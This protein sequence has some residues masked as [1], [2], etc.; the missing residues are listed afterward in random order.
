VSQSWESEIRP[1]QPRRAG[2]AWALVLVPVLAVAVFGF[3]GTVGVVAITEVV[4]D[5]TGVE[6]TDDSGEKDPDHRDWDVSGNTSGNHGETAVDDL[7]PGDCLAQ[8]LP[9][10][11]IPMSVNVVP[12]AERH[13][14]EVYEAVRL[15][16]GPY[17][18]D[19]QTERLARNRCDA[20]F[21]GFDGLDLD[22]SELDVMYVYPI[23]EEQW[24]IEP[25]GV[26]LTSGTEA[27]T[28]SYAGSRR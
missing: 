8:R 13:F 9:E 2:A 23:A 19:R 11:Y 1:P 26:C 16:A 7:A 24:N 4:A 28:G 14:H 25:G 15:G 3:V 10:G 22:D 6:E 27:T 20:A 5:P 21:L 12:C 17:P 18:G